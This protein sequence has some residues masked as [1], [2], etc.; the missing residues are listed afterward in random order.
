MSGIVGIV[1]GDGAPVDRELLGGM[2]DALTFRGPDGRSVWCEANVGFGHTRLSTTEEA[3]C[4]QQPCTL[5]GR[6]WIVA[7]ARIDARAELT[8]ALADRGRPPLDG[9]DDARLILHAYAAWGESCVEHLLGDFAFAIWD[10]AAR[11]LFCARDQFGVKP[12][13]YSQ[14]GRAFVFGNTLEC[15]RLHP[16][17]SSELNDLAIADFLLFDRNMEPDTTAFRDIYRLPAGHVLTWNLADGAPIVRRY[18]QVPTETEIRYRT[19]TD[20]VDRFKELLTS[21]V[22][23]RLR[24]RRV[25]VA[26]SGGLDSSMVA[27][28]AKRILADAGQPF[29]L[30]AHTVVYDHLMHDEERKYA[31]MVARALRVPINF[32]VADGYTPFDRCDARDGALPEPGSLAF[33]AL[34]ADFY[35]QVAE[36]SR[37]L[38]TGHDADALLAESMGEHMTALARRRQFGR[39]I[40][41][42]GRH[43]LWFHRRPPLGLRA[44]KRRTFGGVR[45]SGSE[46]PEWLNPDLVSDL[47]LDE[48]WHD[49]R[50][51]RADRRSVRPRA[52]ACMQWW[53]QVFESGDAGVLGVP[54]EYRYPFADVRLVSYLLAIPVVPWCTDKTLIRMALEDAVPDAIRQRQKTPVP[55]DQV[56]LVLGQAADPSIDGF[57]PVDSFAKYVKRSA[58]PPNTGAATSGDAHLN[59]RPWNLNHWL[60]YGVENRHPGP[61][62]GADYGKR[63]ATDQDVRSS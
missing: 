18:W 33:R 47:H 13:F 38:L 6:A 28:T 12:F 16:A 39:L 46:L 41:T 19:T 37:V 52:A 2:T 42:I 36:Q 23:D 3:V 5:D 30:Q 54:I 31:G 58:V 32:F 22:S 20:Y 26:M 15:V 9:V 4:E 45:P 55:R 63:H 61:L 50:R 27:A 17:V 8:R 53:S 62:Q 43:A 35:T 11:R 48:R 34:A 21:A 44:W 49:V 60:Q 40:S 56:E 29:D 7:D 59:L 25:A 10:K 1:S 14:R 24:T 57:R 51:R